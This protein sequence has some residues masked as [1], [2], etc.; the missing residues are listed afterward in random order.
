MT[1]QLIQI[2][3]GTDGINWAE[4]EKLL[5]LAGL[6]GRTG[7]KLRRAFVNSQLV[8]CAYVSSRIVAWAEL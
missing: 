1:Q 3:Y 6:Q 4:L 8:C 5:A 2:R 7:D